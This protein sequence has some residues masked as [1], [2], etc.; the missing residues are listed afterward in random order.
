MAE[1]W[2]VRDGLTLCLDRNFPDV[3]IELD[4]KAIIDMIS[5]PN[6]PNSI[7]SSNVNDCKQLTTRIPKLGLATTFEKRTDVWITLQ[8]GELTNP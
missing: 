7:I 2:V 6:Q 8:K 4:A 1:L 3:I 5:N